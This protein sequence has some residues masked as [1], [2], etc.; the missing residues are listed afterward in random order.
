MSWSRRRLHCRPRTVVALR[1]RRVS[2]RRGISTLFLLRFP[3]TA[4]RAIE[5]HEAQRNVSPR[6]S[7]GILL[8]RKRGLE[9]ED[10]REVNRTVAVLVVRNLNRALSGSDALGQI[11]RPL[12]RFGVGDDR[13]FGFAVRLQ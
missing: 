2:G 1:G 8:R 5:L 4:Q 13:V 12:L 3:S 9:D 10:R 7:Q 6:L 11:G